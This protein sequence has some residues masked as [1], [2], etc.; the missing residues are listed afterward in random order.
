VKLVAA[1]IVSLTLAPAAAATQRPQ[2][3]PLQHVPVVYVNIQMAPCPAYR[4]EISCYVPETNTI[5]LDD[6]T[7]LPHELG[8]AY[9]RQML[10]QPDRRIL[11][12]MLGMQGLRWFWGNWNPMTHSPPVEEFFADAYAECSWE[13]PMRN[14]KV[15]RWLRNRIPIPA[16]VRV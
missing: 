5:W 14:R 13:A 10:T 12:R 11:A 7:L 16:F 9:D 4:F 15:C 3:I 8:H 2:T 1:L 6:Y